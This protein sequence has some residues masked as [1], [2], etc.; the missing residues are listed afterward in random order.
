[1]IVFPMAGLSSRFTRA[2][3]KQPKYMLPLGSDTMFASV[4]KGFQA[5]FE[6]EPFLFICRDIE[7]TPRFIKTELARMSPAPRQVEVIVLDQETEGQA[8]TVYL[9]LKA[10]QTD[11]SNPL[12]IFNIDSLRHAFTYPED[13]DLSA[14]DGYLEVFQGDGDHWSFVKPVPGQEAQKVAGQVTEKQRISD[15]CSTGLYYFRTTALFC[16]LFENTLASASKDLQG[17]ER[18]IAPLYNDALQSG[19]D[20]RYSV[21]S[22][23][24]ITFTG[25]PDEYESYVANLTSKP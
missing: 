3:Y 15:L 14:I 4:V 17:G 7:D 23:Q 11:P 18:Y 13:L 12:T 22:P 9:G 25:T 1:M 21:I 8:E 10:A 19:Y 20:I 6:T 5:C 16:N 2:G 24:E